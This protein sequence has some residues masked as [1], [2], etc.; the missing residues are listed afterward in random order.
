[1]NK[2]VLAAHIAFNEEWLFQLHWGKRDSLLPLIK[3]S[4]GQGLLHLGSGGIH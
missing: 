2:W 3:G 4:I 1:M